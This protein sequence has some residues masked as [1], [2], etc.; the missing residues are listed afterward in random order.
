MIGEKGKLYSAGD[1]GKEMQLLGGAKEPE[2]ITFRESPGHFKEFAQA[3]Q[4][5]PPALSNFPEFA[6][7]LT[8]MVLLGNLA[9]WT[10]DSGSGPKIDWDAKNLKATNVSNLD[11]VIKPEFRPGYSI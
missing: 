6:G 5:G 2:G 3:I 11:H 8:E 4:G 7:P 1:D 10:A 9:V